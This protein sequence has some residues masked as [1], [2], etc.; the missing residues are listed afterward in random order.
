MENK[1]KILTESSLII[2][3]LFILKIPL[4]TLS[5]LS[6]G[7]LDISSLFVYFFA[8]ILIIRYKEIKFYQIFSLV[9]VLTILDFL[10]VTN[11]IGMIV[12][13]TKFLIDSIMYF[14]VYHFFKSS[15]NK[16]MS[17]QFVFISA[18]VFS[19]I[20][21]TF[22]SVLTINSFLFVSGNHFVPVSTL[23]SSVLSGGM[24]LNGILIY[25]LYIFY[26]KFKHGKSI[27]N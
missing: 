24:L 27:I 9:S 20:E 17:D 23:F 14:G 1:L 21:N 8:I 3:S 6:Y 11:V 15:K 5:I 26:E 25:S 4:K 18:Y 19:V 12:T 2:A 13:V 7:V 22:V 16:W 10:F